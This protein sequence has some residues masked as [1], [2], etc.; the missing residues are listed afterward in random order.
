LYRA[1]AELRERKDV[2]GYDIVAWALEKTGR[3]EEA[4][5]A[6]RSALRLNTPDPLLAAHARVI[7]VSSAAPVAAE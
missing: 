4:Q 5:A 2:Y 3:H 6:M 1:E 7:G